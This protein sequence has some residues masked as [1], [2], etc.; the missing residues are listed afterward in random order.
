MSFNN[1]HRPC[2]HNTWVK[3]GKKR[4]KHRKTGKAFREK[5]RRTHHKSH[6]K[7]TLTQHGGTHH[8]QQAAKRT[9]A[10]LQEEDYTGVP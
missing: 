10:P 9:L 6:R 3:Q 7:H 2:N 8:Q 4:G 5:S 1:V